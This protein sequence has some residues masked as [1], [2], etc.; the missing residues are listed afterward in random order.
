MSVFVFTEGKKIRLRGIH[1]MGEN[2]I[3]AGNVRTRGRMLNTREAR[4]TDGKSSIV[5]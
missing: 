5:L 2:L 1:I 3:R 4:I